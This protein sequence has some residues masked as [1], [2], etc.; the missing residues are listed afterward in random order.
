MLL[1]S[2]GILLPFFASGQSA[3]DWFTYS[4]EAAKN[5]QSITVPTPADV[6]FGVFAWG[7]RIIVGGAMTLAQMGQSLLDSVLNS[8]ELQQALT[9]GN[10]KNAQTVIAGW[11]AVRDFTNMFIVLGFVIIGLAFILR[12]EGYASYKLLFRLII[13][14]LLIN[15][16]LLMCGIFIDGTNITV[17]YFLGQGGAG[18]SGNHITAPI[19]SVAMRSTVYDTINTASREENRDWRTMI[20]ATVSASIFAILAAM[21]FFIYSILFIFRQVALMC[22]I[23]LSPLAFVCYVFPHTKSFFDKWLSQFMQWSLIAIPATFFIWL[24]AQVAN[25]SFVYDEATKTY[26]SPDLLHFFI[27]IAF[28][29]FG[30]FLTFQISAMGAPAAL[31]LASGAMGFATGMG[32]RVT[33]GAARLAA[34]ATG[35]SRVGQA[36]GDRATAIGERLGLVSHGTLAQRQETRQK[37]AGGRINLLNRD[38]KARLANGWA[39]T[40]EQRQNK[41]AAIRSLVENGD[42]DQLRDR[43]AALRYVGTGSSKGI[44][45]IRREFR[46]KDYRFAAPADRANQLE[47]NWS[48]M[49]HNERRNVDITDLTPEFIR[50][51]SVSELNAFRLLPAGHAVRTHLNS[52]VTAGA[53]PAT[54]TLRVEIDLQNAISSGDVAEQRRLTALRTFLQSM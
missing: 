32:A 47:A 3:S 23:I 22:L 30:Y 53:L 45:E 39:L 49:S 33:G 35:A 54:P 15:F 21:L 50:R 26:N 51:R 6:S 41:I 12:L 8:N 16:S 14:A 36:M 43:E 25:N 5:I 48:S 18:I 40:S 7:C 37:E 29:Y 1:F 2:V 13:T 31:G 46:K 52:L 11:T 20:A 42:S 28:L 44:D 10:N 17:N 9:R 38:E 34:G 24:G 27:P 4:I 19:G